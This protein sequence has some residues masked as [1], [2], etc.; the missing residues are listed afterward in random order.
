MTVVSNTSPITNLAAIG[1]LDLLHQLF[2]R[3]LV[4][5]AVAEELAQDAENSP[6][7][8]IVDDVDWLAVYTVN[9]AALAAS[10]ELDIG[11][12]EAIVLAGE[13]NAQFLL[14]DERRGRHAAAK[15]GLTTIGVVGVLI[16]AKRQRLIDSLRPLLDELIARAGF[17][18]SRSLY[19][20]ALRE[21]SEL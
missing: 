18:V 5:Q 15:L 11:E 4:P 1:R 16:E 2:G 14:I 6:G 19:A 7:R 10:L 13:L 3:V 8:V 12:A 21:V 17:W 9:D 20:Q